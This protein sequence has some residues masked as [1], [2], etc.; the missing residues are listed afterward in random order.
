MS[1]LEFVQAQRQDL[2]IVPTPETVTGRTYIITG[3]NG[4]IGFE[5]VKHL[6]NL[7]ASRVIMAVRSLSKGNEAKSRI[8]SATGRPETLEV[9]HLDMA[10]YAS[11]RAFAKKAATDLDRVD[12]LVENATAGLDTWT[13]SE[14]METSITVNVIGTVLLALLMLPKMRETAARTGTNPHIVVVTS[15]MGF[16]QKSF[17]ETYADDDD[18]FGVLN[19]E[20]KT[21]IHDR[22]IPFALHPA[23]LLQIFV[24]RQLASLIPVSRTGV[25]LN[26]LSPGL[27][28]TGLARHTRLAFRVQNF[29]FN[30]ALG[31]TPEMGSRTILHALAAGRD[32]HGEFISDCQ[33]KDHWVPEYVK[34]ASG[35]RFQERIWSQLA[36]QLERIEPGS[37]ESIIRD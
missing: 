33:I 29:L 30:A 10:S 12:V 20:G 13:T 36:R 16:D 8:D 3:S 14:G 9:W 21:P 28:N 32:S 26:L 34:N 18:I 23:E 24:I 35:Q 6:V 22:Y 17:T 7:G 2:P 19:V 15:G 1:F 11:I 25:V 27:C 37:V 4:G 31:R 5:A